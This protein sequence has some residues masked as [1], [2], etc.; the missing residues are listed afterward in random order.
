MT[1]AAAPS[2]SPSW[3]S[4]TASSRSSPPTA[5]PSSAATTGTMPS[6]IGS[7]AEFK[8]AEGVDLSGQP[9]ALQRIKEEAEKAKIALS[10]STTYDINLPFITA[11]ATG[12]KHIQIQLTRAKLEQLTG[13]TF[14]SAPRSPSPGA[15]RKP[16]SPPARSDELV[17]VGGMTRMPKVQEIGQGT[18]RE[19][20]P[21][22]ASTRTRSWPSERPSRAASSRAMSRMSSSS[23][24]PRSPSPS[25]PREAG[26]PP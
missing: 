11:D 16:A 23:T 13:H 18:R 26:P 12:P 25:R 14:S 3:R 4:A 19:R 24:S 17:L 8:S 7:P 6:S 9:D 10:S 20:P 22:R 5:T 1:S 21:T 15:S 2:T